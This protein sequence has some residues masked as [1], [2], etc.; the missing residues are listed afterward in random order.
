VIY[1]GSN[2][3]IDEYAR[4]PI[5]FVCSVAVLI[6]FIV[7][8]A[9]LGTRISDGMRK[10][11]KASLGAQLS[12]EAVPETW[13]YSIRSAKSYVRLHEFLRSPNIGPPNFG[14]CIARAVRQKNNI[15]HGNLGECENK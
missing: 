13:V 9:K 8:N 15:P 12:N 5:W 11:W 1:S 14:C 4:D 10:I 6:Y 2:F 7:L 3:W